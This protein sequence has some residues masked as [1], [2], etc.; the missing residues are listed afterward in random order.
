MTLAAAAAA[1][2]TAIGPEALSTVAAK[3]QQSVPLFGDMLAAASP[4]AP[5]GRSSD[6]NAPQAALPEPTALAIISPIGSARELPPSRTPDVAEAD[7]RSAT[8]SPSKGAAE[9]RP[10][11]TQTAAAR[12]DLPILLVP[13]SMPM[14]P[15]ASPP[16][17][18][19]PQTATVPPSIPAAFA[20]RAAAGSAGEPPLSGGRRAAILAVD[21]IA[22]VDQPQGTSAALAVAFAVSTPAL[23]TAAAASAAAAASLAETLAAQS[24]AA[25]P[26]AAFTEHDRTD[27][28]AGPSDL[29]GSGAMPP[30]LGNQ[31]AAFA[32]LL[33]APVTGTTVRP[34]GPARDNSPTPS[35]GE[36]P[37]RRSVGRPIELHTASETPADHP[38]PPA[39]GP[40]EA[41]LNTLSGTSA[42]ASLLHDPS[43][44][45]SPGS[46]RRSGTASV[47]ARQ[48]PDASGEPGFR[49]DSRLLGPV[50]AALL[51]PTAGGDRLHVRFTVDRPATAALI[52]GAS[53]R[54]DQT[55]SAT[56]MRLG[57]LAVAVGPRVEL[58]AALP[59]AQRAALP[60][61][62]QAA[63]LASSAA[64]QPSTQSSGS[65]PVLPWSSPGSAPDTAS[66]SGAGHPRHQPPAPAGPLKPVRSPAATAPIRDRFA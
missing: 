40:T 18:P 33:T 59:D 45:P 14:V 43:R 3:P 21:T 60:G 19:L 29:L 28:I 63:P 11:P 44:Q 10:K 56:G 6:L 13:V 46:P 42:T 52:A 38:P 58:A 31:Q 36:N 35:D 54:L 41:T 9:K 50:S 2:S 7:T 16:E 24:D 47:L 64:P 15:I 20:N 34:I 1:S 30:T 23:T 12:D 39:D 51:S 62:L 5:P 53:D 61:R 66:G 27:T 25:G 32:K 37:S 4:S 49:I 55:L 65:Q 17:N 48:M 8:T 57:S 26:S 22:A